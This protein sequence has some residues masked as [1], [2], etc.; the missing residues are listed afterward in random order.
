MARHKEPNLRKAAWIY[1]AGNVADVRALVEKHH[2]LRTIPGGSIQ[3]VGTLRRK[4]APDKIVAVS[5]WTWPNKPVERWMQREYQV[6]PGKGL[7]LSRLIA[8]PSAPRN[9]ATH[10]MGRDMRALKQREF[11]GVVTYADGTE[12]HTGAIYRASNWTP[13]GEARA[14]PRWTHPKTGRTKTQLSAGRYVPVA[15]MRRLGYVRTM[16]KPK[17]RFV[18]GLNRGAQRDIAQRFQAQVRAATANKQP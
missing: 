15:E 11:D 18:R 16:G 6:A 13:A 1:R 10:L 5:I 4:S 14:R 2:Y 3:H 9:T 8:I 12:G 7:N 17:A